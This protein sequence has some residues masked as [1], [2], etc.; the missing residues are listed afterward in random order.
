MQAE[1]AREAMLRQENN[2]AFSGDATHGLVGL[3][4]DPNIPTVTVVDPGAGTEWTAKTGRQMVDDMCSC[5]NAI[6][7]N[8]GDV[9]APTRLLLPTAQYNLAHC[10]RM[11]DG[12]DTTALNYFLQNNPY[13]RE[14]MPVR[15]LTGAGTGGADVMVAYDPQL[16]KLRMN[17][18]MEIEQ[19]PPQEIDTCVKV[20]YRLKSGGLTVHKPLS[21]NICEGI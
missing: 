13:V 1:A 16:S 2:I 20:I 4:T 21:L 15:E 9:E 5:V 7:E 8:T 12:T 3:F 17:I 6:P 18:P 10:T 11:E 14:V 19:L